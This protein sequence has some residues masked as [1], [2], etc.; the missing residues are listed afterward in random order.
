MRELRREHAAGRLPEAARLFMADSKP[1]EELYDTVADP[2]ELK[3]LANDPE[4]RTV[5]ERM[6]AAHLDWVADTRDV[7]LI[8][9]PEIIVREQ[10]LGSRYAILRQ[11]GAEEA[12]AAGLF[13]AQPVGA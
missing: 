3:N 10:A 13:R 2:H 1:P 9:E 12:E 4:Y 5:L 11:E 6:R 8:P 7:G